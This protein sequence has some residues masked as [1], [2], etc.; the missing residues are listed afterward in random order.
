VSDLSAGEVREYVT[1]LEHD[2]DGAE[3]RRIARERHQLHSMLKVPELPEHMTRGMGTSEPTPLMIWLSD[4]ILADIMPYPTLA[5]VTPLGDQTKVAQEAADKIEK[6]ASLFRGRVDEGREATHEVRWHELLSPYGVMILRCGD[7]GDD[8]PWRVDTPDP[9][10]CFFPIEGG[11]SRPDVFARRYK[12]FAREVEKQN[13]KRRNYGASGMF[14]SKNWSMNGGTWQEVGDDYAAEN[15]PAH[16]VGGRFEEVE[17]FELHVDEMIYHYASNRDGKNGKIVWQGKSMTGGVSAVVIPG[18]TTPLREAS[19]RLRPALWPAYQMVLLINKVRAKRASRS[20]NLKPDILAE[21]TPEMITAIQAGQGIAQAQN[22]ALEAGGPNIISVR[23]KPTLWTI[24]DDPDLDKQEQSYWTELNRYIN[25]MTEVSDAEVVKD[26]TANAFLT[27]LESRKR[28]RAPMLANLDWGWKQIVLMAIR[29]IQ[30]Y[31]KD[32]ALYATEDGM[33]KD[34]KRGQGETIGPADVKDW[35]KRFW[36][37]IETR[38]T[39]EAEARMR[40][41]DWAYRKGLGLST[42]EEGVTA[43]GY[44]DEGAQL[45]ALAIDKGVE[46]VGP[47]IAQEIQAATTER[48]RLRSGI[49]LSLGGGAAQANPQTTSPAV[50]STPST[51]EPMRPAAVPGPAGG[52]GVMP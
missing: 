27:N 42:H 32:F 36:L 8:F 4:L 19:E 11:P 2:P 20:D 5:T 45:E 43:A 9:L 48:I 21:Q 15:G 50:T 1:Y 52:S 7:P 14:Q 22:A 6:W 49:M 51:F 3:M 16:S 17:C 10:T 39:T 47:W 41:Q 29:S 18:S 23:G 34:L 35:D 25:S 40:V 28:Q 13:S 44:T 24:Q 31:D 30:E 38:S 26:S 12:Q 46:A 37:A 33:H